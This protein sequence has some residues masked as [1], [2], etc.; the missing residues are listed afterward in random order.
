[1]LTNYMRLNDLLK[2]ILGDK[3]EHEHPW[4]LFSDPCNIKIITELC[5]TGYKLKKALTDTVLSVVFC[6]VHVQ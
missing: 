2:D 4:H 3:R 6:R 1:M 5:R